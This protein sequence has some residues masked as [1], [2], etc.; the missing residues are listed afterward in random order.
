MPYHGLIG[1]GENPGYLNTGYGIRIIDDDL[2]SALIRSQQEADENSRFWSIWSGWGTDDFLGHSECQGRNDFSSRAAFIALIPMGDW[3]AFLKEKQ[4]NKQRLRVHV[5]V[6]IG[7]INL[8][9]DG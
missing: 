1:V 3:S 4:P 9:G 5:P 7:L 2:E 8:T 6:V